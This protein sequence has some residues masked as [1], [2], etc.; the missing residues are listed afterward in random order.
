M[1]HSGW[2]VP[3]LF[4]AV[5]SGISYLLRDEFTTN[6]SA[7]LTS[8][9]TC[10]PGPGTLTFYDTGNYL[11]IA[12]SKLDLNGGG[13][14]AYGNPGA[15]S[16]S[17]FTRAAGLCLV[18]LFNM[19]SNTSAYFGFTTVTWGAINENG[20]RISSG[21]WFDSMAGG[22][23]GGDVGFST[24]YPT[25]TCLVILRSAGAFTI[26]D[27]ILQFV[28][29]LGTTAN[30]YAGVTSFSLNATLDYMR[31]T[32]LTGV[33]GTDYGIATNRVA[34]PT[35]PTAT[36]STVDAITEFTWTPA[37]AETLEL[38]VRRTDA[39][40]RWIVRC[41]QGS[42][43]IKLIECNAGVETERSSAA[44]TFTIGTARRIVV[45]AAGNTIKTH[46]AG[47]L[48]NSYASAS[49]NNTATGVNVG[50]FATG[51]NLV[52]YPRDVSAYIPAGI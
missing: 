8:P 27:G 9:R 24:N 20:M 43:T 30:V 21:G 1:I 15:W 50:G 7:P 46:A 26:V 13:A 10:E 6:A 22:G 35:S 37:A 4:S 32:S 29:A 44:Q 52:C 45:L 36:T 12:S 11:S 19:R 41:S 17:T 18:T 2:K 47:A 14:A 3:V 34:S 40:N 23:T 51:S 48:K 42:S 38:D 49:F 5:S 31:V 16:G 33:W 25:G 28:S 39:N